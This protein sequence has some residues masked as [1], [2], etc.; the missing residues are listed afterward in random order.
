MKKKSLLLLTT[1]LAGSLMAACNQNS[2]G[3]NSN[4]PSNVPSESTNN[5]TTLP[6][7]SASP[8]MT[9]STITSDKPSATPS[10]SVIENDGSV[11]INK[12]Q[13]L[14]NDA[15]IKDITNAKSSIVLNEV[16]GYNNGKRYNQKS[17]INSTSYKNDLTIG[18]GSIEHFNY[19]TPNAITKDTFD[20]VYTIKSNNFIY[21]RKYK[22]GFFVDDT[23]KKSLLFGSSDP[24][25]LEELYEIAQSEVTCG[26]GYDAYIQFYSAIAETGGSCLYGSVQD[27]V[28]GNVTLRFE[29]TYESEQ[30]NQLRKCTFVFQ[31]DNVD[32]GFL[33]MFEVT[34]N[35][36]S[37]NVYNA[38]EDKSA[39]VPTYYSNQIFSVSKGTLEDFTGK[40]P[41]DIDES[42]VQEIKVSSS[43][44]TIEVDEVIA[45][46]WKVLP[47][48]ALNKT[49]IVQS[50]N[51]NVAR[52]DDDGRV[53]GI[54]AGKAVIAVINPESGV[55]GTIELTVVNKNKPD[56]GDDA[57]KANLKK[58]LEDSY[59]QVFDDNTNSYKYVGGDFVNSSSGMCI[60]AEGTIDSHLLS[61]LSISDFTYDESLRKATYYGDTKNVI[62][63]LPFYDNG[64]ENL[65]NNFLLKDKK[66]LYRDTILGFELYLKGDGTISYVKFKLRCDYISWNR[67]VDFATLTNDNVEEKLNSTFTVGWAREL[68]YVSEGF[69]YPDE[70]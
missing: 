29:T 18:S 19:E 16:I 41:I 3:S 30:T 54:S 50:K 52:V 44:T 20:E 4:Q 69:V 62:N 61:A 58:A 64:N 25:E 37:L 43:K 5:S 31:F 11:N 45:I 57:K 22:N 70:K 21:M 10:T 7:T 53:T 65:T 56:T 35:L 9:P 68:Y 42:F 49:V 17:T 13:L 8:S 28:T 55:E 26:A 36:Y 32:N 66:N 6:S 33:Q 48:T 1:L 15:R 59:Y 23:Q 34:Q 39:V 46:T 40:L 27:K 67:S 24:A 38:A 60:D 47:E 2:S 12:A 63:L 51:E 14:V